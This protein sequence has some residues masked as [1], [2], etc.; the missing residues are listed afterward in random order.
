[1]DIR[2]DPQNEIH[3]RVDPGNDQGCVTAEGFVRTFPHRHGTDGFFIAVLERE[4]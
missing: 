2:V 1:M 4:R 3:I